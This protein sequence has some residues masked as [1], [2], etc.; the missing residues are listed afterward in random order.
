MDQLRR[1]PVV[2]RWVIVFTD[3]PRLPKDFE[4]EP[5]EKR[6]GPC[7]FCYGH[8]TMTPP[9]IQAHR[10]GATRA[11]SPG[12]S[13][14]VVPNKFPA[15]RIEGNLDRQGLGIFD[16]S[17][18]VGAHEVIIET[19][20]H[21]KSLADLLDHEAEK[22]IWAYRDRSVDLHGDKRFRYIMIF[23]NHGYTAGASLAHSHSQLIAL[24]MV[25]KN[26]KEELS[27]A[28]RYYE[29]RER[30]IF[31]DMITQEKEESKRLICEN[32]RFLAFSPFASRFPFETWILP[33]EHHSDFS[34]IRTE[35]V[36]ELA[37]ILKEVLLRMKCVLRDPPYNFIVHTAPIEQK[38]REDYHWHIE[39]MPK[40]M[41]VAGFE[42]GSGFY[43]NPTP[44][45]IAAQY[46]REAK[47]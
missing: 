6:E 27:G 3:K 9:E 29:Y 17:N 24:P 37:R 30:C 44:P 39:I 15:L 12:W 14:R 16:M 13:T 8:E 4:A 21:S 43:I 22:V 26:V 23:K 20:D 40:L 28:N 41:R 42:W 45:E 36:V 2:G 11:N 25:P 10:E 5:E 47:I 19:P 34:F 35:D 31:C 18:G 1:D 32:S 7:P 46:L 38:E 33:K